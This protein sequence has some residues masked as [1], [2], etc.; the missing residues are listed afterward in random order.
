VEPPSKTVQLVIVPLPV[1]VEYGAGVGGSTSLAGG[2]KLSVIDA[3]HKASICAEAGLAHKT[4]AVA[5]KAKERTFMIGLLFRFSRPVRPQGCG[6][7]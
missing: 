7:C 6:A 4:T 1:E 2:S 5:S 3:V